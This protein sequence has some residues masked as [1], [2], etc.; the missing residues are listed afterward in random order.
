VILRRP[1]FAQIDKRPATPQ[2]ANAD[3]TKSPQLE[4]LTRVPEGALM[5]QFGFALAH[6]L[7][8]SPDK[9][10]RDVVRLVPYRQYAGHKA[11]VIDLS[12]SKVC[13]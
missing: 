2:G 7:L 11:D 12:W 5:C 9:G 10:G 3:E 6:A 1:V 8:D 4:H 13:Q